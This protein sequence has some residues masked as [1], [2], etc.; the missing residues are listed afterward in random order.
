M[1]KQEILQSKIVELSEHDDWNVAKEQWWLSNI[2]FLEGSTCLCTHTP[3]TECCEMVNFVNH[4]RVV[5]GNCCVK[6]FWNLD[7]KS[8]F[9]AAKR[10][11]QDNVKSANKELVE[12]AYDNHWITQWE[13]GFYLD[14]LGKR[15]LSL[16][17]KE[18]RQ[19]INDKILKSLN[20]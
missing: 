5:V 1:T 20:R 13:C 11:R 17:Q 14:T 18:V 15:K 8:I 16:K 4:N 6:K 9:D 7:N 19:R 2:Y 10:I 12:M 3:I